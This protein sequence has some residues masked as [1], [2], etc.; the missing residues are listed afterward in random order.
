MALLRHP[1]IN[2]WQ[3]NVNKSPTCQHDLISSK[4]LIDLGI[5]IVALQEPAI[6]HVH[7]TIATKDWIS[8]YPSTHSSKPEKTRSVLLI[9][10]AL[11]SDSWQQMD[12]PSGDVTIIQVNGTWGKLTIFNIYND[13]EHNHT[14]TL[15]TEYLHNHADETNDT[16]EGNVHNIWLGDF[17]RH[18][19]HWDDPE[20][21]RL[22]TR[23]ALN[24]AELLIEAVAEA[25]LEM[26]LPSGM[27][28]HQH[29]VS[30]CWS[31]L[32][33][34]FLSDHST[35]LLISCATL[36][37][38]RGVCTDHLPILTKLDMS[39]Q[40][41][42]ERSFHNFRD[43]DWDQFRKALGENL[44]RLDPQ[45]P[46]ISQTQLD[47]SCADL[48]NVIQST[49]NNNVP[50]TRICAKSK[51]W[52]TK[53]LTT[54]RKAAK[55]LG[56]QSF[57][58]KHLPF[59][60]TH[61]AHADANKTYHRTLES[62]KK[63]HWRDWLEKA[64]DPDI[65]TVQRLLSAPAS[66]GGGSKV[67]TLKY[68]SGGTEHLAKTN[69][70]KGKALVKSFFP[71]KPHPE[72]QL[73]D[74]N[75]PPQCCKASQ[76]TRETILRQLRRLK[77]YKAPGPDGIPNVILTKCADLLIDRLYHIYTAIYNKRL[78]YK[79]WKEFNT[80]VLRKPGKPSYE[81]PKAYRP[82]AL[83]NTLWKVLTAILAEQLT[84]VAE[85]H[86]LLPDHHFGGRPG[87]TTTDAM[88]LLTYKIKSAW[89]QGKVAAVLFL[90]VEGAF[91][92][93]V[94]SILLHNMRK[95]KVP[96]KLINF[97]AGMLEGRITN[98]KFDDFTSNPIPIDNGIGQG[99]PLSM[100][101]YQFYNADILDIPLARNE[102]AIAYVDD[103]LLMATADTF[104]EAHQTLSNMMTRR[105]GAMDWSN[106]HNSPLEFSKL[107][108]ID[109][110][111]QNVSKPRPPL[112]LPHKT[113]EP[114]TSAKYLGVIFDQNL[115]WTTQLAQVTEKGSKWAS[116]IR[117][118]TR[119]SWG[120][121]PSYARR[122]FI[123]VALPKVLYAIDIWCTPIHGKGQGPR[124]KGSAA[125][126]KQLTAVQRAGTLAITGGLR[127]SPTDAL[128][129]LAYT[130]PATQLIDKWCSKAAVR[131]ATVPP[132][133]PLFKLVKSSAKRFVNRH[134]APL[135]HLMHIFKLNPSAIS[136][137][138]VA[139]RN[140]M[141]NHKLH[142]RISIANSKESSKLEAANA[143]ER[144]KVYSDG[145]EINGKV[146]AAALLFRP[147]KPTRTLHY[148]LGRD[149][150][151]TIQEA[152][153]VGLLLG[154]HLVKTETAGNTTYALGTDNQAA[155]K[156]LSTPLVQSSQKI[157]LTVL[158]TAASIQ[159]RRASNKYALT[160]RWTAG[161]SGIDGNEQADKAAKAAAGG[162]SSDKKLLPP[163]LRNK[164][165]INPTAL[166]REHSKTIKTKWK[167]EWTQS[168]RGIKMMTLDGTTPS[169]KLLKSLSNA[170]LT[171]KASSII[172]QICIGHFPLNEYLYRFKRVDNPRCPA[173]GASVE[174][175][176]HFLFHCRSYAHMRWPLEQKCKGRLS[177]K[178]I[179]A[180]PELTE[181]L[182]HYI[183]AT[184]RFKQHEVSTQPQA[185]NTAQ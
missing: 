163:L 37:E 183:D 11:T 52:W 168:R 178:A 18:H 105:H 31:R 115:K 76:F 4:S 39:V 25:G 66:D 13:C 155:I 145:S 102:S 126:V 122:L 23:D 161:H 78:Y 119:P 164:L 96:A 154:L 131:L 151:H 58:F 118:A 170:K 46:I 162:A 45:T 42:P 138:A 114:I 98:L 7:M 171:R 79:P 73:E 35:D 83:I 26:I 112:H 167:R 50:K 97:A 12:F 21:T 33:N 148:H 124:A 47:K 86:R 94:P 85:K 77:P 91:P 152:E 103:A 99:D 62:T 121:T 185:S 60:H 106:S 40:T 144:I 142:L 129:A 67:P 174:T 28:T 134:K 70:E 84:F 59:H 108:L 181:S 38:Q 158:K 175:I 173:C 100:A 36:P 88:H 92:N 109:F 32:D 90:D 14:V 61:A 93:A 169:N 101:L 146:G 160:L 17:N 82:I 149:T 117:R 51:R 165:T 87:R 177:L 27:P 116:Q 74:T 72:P 128:D 132:E 2:I 166:K 65:W 6:N 141:D 180:S 130:I 107:A 68:K 147:G 104:E 8:I 110:A 44:E 133:H 19:P 54:L 95:R 157:A 29:N 123:G 113:I 20:D 34:V 136:K 63:N 16:E 153:M 48:T 22:F 9:S 89:R 143:T 5:N 120:I 81:V 24:A 1:N 182:T 10:A 184:G 53:E 135:H 41:N 176:N 140:P 15:L 43:I 111:H 71:P 156:S 80:I 137:I 49:I 30:K 139:V 69:E 159:K 57:K 172:A 56:R 125:A 3:Q 127:T 75:Y 55:R 150:E 64:K 179:L